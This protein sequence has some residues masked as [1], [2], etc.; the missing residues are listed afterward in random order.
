MIRINKISN[1][2]GANLEKKITLEEQSRCLKNTKNNV[3]PGSGR[4]ID[5]FYRVFWCNLKNVILGVVHQFFKDRQLPITLSLGIFAL[6]SKGL[7][8]RI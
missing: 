4:F 8:D 2:K 1:I 3:A 5:T 6:I 7:K